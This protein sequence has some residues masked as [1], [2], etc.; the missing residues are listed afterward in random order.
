M[1]ALSR[2]C[3][4]VTWLRLSPKDTSIRRTSIGQFFS[5]FS[6]ILYIDLELKVKREQFLAAESDRKHKEK[7]GKRKKP[8]Q[9][10]TDDSNNP[11]S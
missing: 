6:F 1:R 11:V 3:L 9:A 7:I 10:Q 4:P 5:S 8:P 2:K